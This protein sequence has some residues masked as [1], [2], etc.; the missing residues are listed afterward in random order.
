MPIF[1]PREDVKDCIP[2]QTGRWN[3]VTCREN[4]AKKHQIYN[5]SV[6]LKFECQCK[7][8]WTTMK[9]R[10]EI[11]LWKSPQRNNISVCLYLQQCQRCQKWV[12]PTPYTKELD[13]VIKQKIEKWFHPSHVKGQRYRSTGK[14][15]RNHD[16]QRCEACKL[17]KCTE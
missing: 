10:C 2:P 9:G 16:S 12:D 8:R 7:R 3:V 4:V 13:S 14:P 15:T 1:L 5:A 6:K 11:K 17:G